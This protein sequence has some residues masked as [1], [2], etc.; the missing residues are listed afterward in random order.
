MAAIQWSS[1]G[2]LRAIL[3]ATLTEARE[4]TAAQANQRA[5]LRAAI[6]QAQRADTP[7][8]GMV[9]L[10]PLFEK[11]AQCDALPELHTAFDGL[12]A[13]AKSQRHLQRE[14]LEERV[15]ALGRLQTQ[16][17]LLIDQANAL[18]ADWPEADA[19]KPLRDYAKQA[20]RADLTAFLSERPFDDARANLERARQK[21]ERL[22]AEAEATKSAWWI[23]AGTGLGGLFVLYVLYAA[24]NNLLARKAERERQARQRAALES[25]RATMA[26]RRH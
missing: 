12:F 16:P 17:A 26:R 11:Y 7:L 3:E 14:G 13:A 15:A 20:G 21:A 9:A 25:V 8:K 2:A 19:P 24:I 10:L 5:E 18:L 22:Q 4:R 1:V 23:W 6:A